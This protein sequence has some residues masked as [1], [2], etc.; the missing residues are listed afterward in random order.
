MLNKDEAHKLMIELIALRKKAKETKS[1][2]DEKKF[3][4]QE[5]LC[6]EKFE[7]L[8]IMHT[9]QYKAFV[10]YEDLYQDGALALMSAMNNYN[11]KK[12]NF[13]WWAHKYIGTKIARSA[14]LHT[15]IRFPL[16]VAKKVAPHK[17]SNLPLLIENI[18][19]PDIKYE[20][21]QTNFIIES[22]MIKLTDEQKNI[23]TLAYGLDGDK[24][25]SVNKLCKRLGMTR[26]KC[27]KKLNEALRIL[28]DDMRLK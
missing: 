2:I 23:I 5:K 27:I 15:T 18:N 12:G 1:V 8:I 21:E 20:K 4:E 3:K 19:R 28:K 17:E 6:F 16:K 13:F 7:Y 26:S 22:A 9:H 24:P 11:P 14:N 25:L 10:N